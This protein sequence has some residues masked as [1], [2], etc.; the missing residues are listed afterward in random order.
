MNN[1]LI[2]KINE[3]PSSEVYVNR[4]LDPLAV[5]HAWFTTDDLKSL[6]A[7][8]TLANKKLELALHCVKHYA[9]EY[10]WSGADDD[11][12]TEDFWELDGNGYDHARKILDEIARLE[13]GRK[14]RNS[15]AVIESAK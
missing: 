14:C 4:D 9:T 11:D 7:E 12:P 13:G 6:A 5:F 3:L 8:L 1:E 10:F 2:E 15:N